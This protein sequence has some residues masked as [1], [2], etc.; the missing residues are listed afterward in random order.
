MPCRNHPNIRVCWMLSLAA[1]DALGPGARLLR[2]ERGEP[3]GPGEVA[4]AELAERLKRAHQRL[5][6]AQQKLE[7]TQQAVDAAE[8]AEG[9]HTTVNTADQRPAEAA[10]PPQQAASSAPAP[11]RGGVGPSATPQPQQAQ[12]VQAQAQ[13]QQ[14]ESAGASAPVPPPPLPPP[15]QQGQP[16]GPPASTCPKGI[17]PRKRAAEGAERGPTAPLAKRP[18]LQA[19]NS[20]DEL[21]RPSARPGLVSA[22]AART[23]EA[24][25]Q[26]PQAAAARVG[27]PA[28][29]A[30]AGP[31]SAAAL[32]PLR[33]AA[34]RPAVVQGEAEQQQ[35]IQRQSGGLQQEIDRQRSR[36]Q[37]EIQRQS[38]SSMQQPPQQQRSS[39]MQQ[40]QPQQRRSGEG[41]TPLRYIPPAARVAPKP[42]T[43]QRQ[44]GS[45]FSLHGGASAGQLWPG[46]LWGQA[47]ARK[48]SIK[49]M[50]V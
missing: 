33:Y 29:A 43:L 30:A 35:E 40:Q 14:E 11:L 34:Q 13:A 23:A 28:V 26:C 37:Q 39:S 17:S 41:L 21:A 38:S 19:H 18:A 31:S 47:Y 49:S 2:W 6:R 44:V 48:H 32:R 36:L 24:G 27:G 4:P 22:V 1:G 5:R 42:S 25:P 16:A 20:S 7:R 46:W 12:Q 10:A 3:V 9:Q 8:A 15:Q 45:C 50:G